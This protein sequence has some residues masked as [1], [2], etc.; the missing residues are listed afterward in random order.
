ME[1]D[2]IKETSPIEKYSNCPDCGARKNEECLDP[3]TCVHGA[4]IHEFIAYANLDE[5]MEQ[6]FYTISHVPSF[7]RDLILSE[8][9]S[10]YLSKEEFYLFKIKYKLLADSPNPF[11]P[12]L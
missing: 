2:L 6:E 7:V 11:I 10:L 12:N 9:D 5:R 1:I 8:E 4:R 3:E